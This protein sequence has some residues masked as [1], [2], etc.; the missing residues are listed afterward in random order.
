[1]TDFFV[2]LGKNKAAKNILSKVGVSAPPTLARASDPWAAD[3][4][5]GSTF[6][7][8]SLGNLHDTLAEVVEEAGGVVSDT[9]STEERVGGLV[10]DASEVTSVGD[11][12]SVY[13][14]FHPRIRGVGR[15]GRLVVVAR[16]VHSASS[17]E[18]ASVRRALEGFVR[19][20]A[21][22]LGRKGATANLI[23][24]AAGAEPRVGAAL[25]FFLSRRS[26]FV[27]GQKLAVDNTVVGDDA[28][29]WVGSLEGRT[30]LVTGSARGI[31][32]AIAGAL[33][34][35]GAHVICVDLPSDARELEEVAADIGGSAFTQDIAAPD[36][37]KKLI[38]FIKSKRGGLDICI[39]NAG[40]TRDKTLAKMS[41]E[42]WDLVMAVNLKAIHDINTAFADGLLNDGGRILCMASIA[43]IAGNVGQT[44]YAASKAGVIG[45]VQ[46]L[47]PQLAKRGISVNAVAPGFI[48]TRM[49]A[50]IPMFTKEAGRRLSNLSQGGLPTDVADAITF[51]STPQ[52]IGISGQVLRV[53][54]GSLLGA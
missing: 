30:A 48:E 27:S 21:K 11:L 25:R 18:E 5:G 6:V 2:E 32:E 46:H 33:A 43:G 52:A 31:G 7:L 28:P 26:A 14:F 8:G 20:A 13:D 34:A 51:L 49:T 15:S 24:V 54:G 22:E 44:N 45:L 41:P 4:L 35:E 53:C 37:P 12:K 42:W 19:S 9:E 16:P 23:E 40:V 3:E 29:P 47:A 10:F 39:H 36:A 1:M 17:V 50:Q 38:D